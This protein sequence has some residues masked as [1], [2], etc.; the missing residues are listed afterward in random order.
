[1]RNA[2][3]TSFGVLGALFLAFVALMW[4]GSRIPKRPS[5]ISASGIF[6]ERGSVPFKLSMHGDWL[7]C[8]R[9]ARI[10]ADRCRLTDEKGVLKFEDTFL[11]YQAHALVPEVE[12]EIDPK[13]T[14]H[15]WIGVTTQ[16][17]SLPIIFMQNGEILL[18]QSE[19]QK[20]K[21]IVDFWVNGHSK[22]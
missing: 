16:N 18:P 20:A 13:K 17:V 12:L 2:L 21:K 1:M 4:W 15:L 8:W 22:G 10:G 9:D 5:N 3:F 19:Y 6:I 7:D 11:P 14:G